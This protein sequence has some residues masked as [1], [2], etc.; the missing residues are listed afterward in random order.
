MGNRTKY[1]SQ[2]G[3][4][5]GREYLEIKLQLNG[6][7]A[8]TVLRGAGFLAITNPATHTGGT[9]AVVVTLRDGYPEAVVHS[10]DVRDDAGSGA[11]A[12][13]GNFTGEGS[14]SLTPVGFT[15]RT[16]NAGGSAANDSSLVVVVALALRNS[17]VT[18]G[19]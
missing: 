17:S 8:P 12:T 15:I 11:Y 7:S 4:S 10:V 2:S 19:N 5:V 14:G 18:A 6:A 3:G 13:I 16:F 9:N 1:P